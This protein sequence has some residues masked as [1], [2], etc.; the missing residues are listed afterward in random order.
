M[1]TRTVYRICGPG[2]TSLMHYVPD[3]SLPSTLRD[4]SFI[5]E[6]AEA[7]DVTCLPKTT[8]LLGSRMCC[9][10]SCPSSAGETSS[11]SPSQGLTGPLVPT[12]KTEILYLPSPGPLRCM[13]RGLC[14]ERMSQ[15]SRYQCS[16]EPGHF[17]CLS[18]SSCQPQLLILLPPRWHLQVGSNA[19]NG[20]QGPGA[21]ECLL[22]LCSM[23]M[24]PRPLRPCVTLS[25][26]PDL[27]HFSYCSIRLS[28]T[29]GLFQ[30]ESLRASW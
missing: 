19:Q 24:T 3:F 25:F 13:R 22:W 26:W 17:L 29:T 4:H 14:E 5:S 12:Y 1:I 6:E 7:Q 20:V 30:E 27:H 28:Q 18:L 10:H 11:V 23:T 9:T 2:S 15:G 21:S 8:E 16:A